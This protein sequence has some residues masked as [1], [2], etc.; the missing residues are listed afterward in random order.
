MQ[1]NMS[2]IRIRKRNNSTGIIKHSNFN[3][4]EMSLYSDK[5]V[6]IK[7][8]AFHIIEHWQ[9]L[10]ENTNMSFDK[11]LYVFEEICKNCT[12]GEINSA[13]GV[14][15]EA[16]TKVRDVTQLMNSIKYRNSR[17]KTK[18]STKV[19]NNLSNMATANNSSIDSLSN[20]IHS[21]ISSLNGG[22]QSQS[23]GDTSGVAQECFTKLLD[24]AKVMNECDRIIKNYNII[25]K[26]FN[27]NKMVSE[28][29][30][31]EEVYDTIIEMCS[32]I[33]TYNTEFKNKYNTALENTYYVFNNNYM[34]YPAEKIV[35]SV[36]DYFI[37]NNIVTDEDVNTISTVKESNVV[38][39]KNDFNRV[40]YLFKNNKIN[41]TVELDKEAASNYGVDFYTLNESSLKKKVKEWSKGNPDEH[42][43]DDT[44]K[45]VSDFRDSC[46]EKKSENLTTNLKSLIT[47]LFTK[48]PEQITKELPNIFSIIR[49]FFILGTVPINPIITLVLFIADNMIKLNLERKHLDK[50]IKMYDKEIEII[51]GK[52]EKDKS[53]NNKDRLNKYLEALKK[54]LKKIKEYEEDLYTDNENDERHENDYEFDDDDTD[55]DDWDLDDDDDWNF[56]ESQLIKSSSIIYI[57]ELVNSINEALLDDNIDGVVYNNIFKFNDDTID[58]ITDFSIT[59]PLI[60]EKDKL[61]NSLESLRNNIRENATNVNDF[62]RIDCLN[63][64]I[65]KIKNS[66]NSFNVA[67]D[68]KGI[69]CTLKWLEEMTKSCNSE[70]IT[71][72][73]FTNTLKLSMNRL[74]KSAIKLSGK[75]KQI[76]N[77]ID[78]SMR[79][80]SKGMED[81]MLKDNKE[82]II[83]GRILPSA[84]RVIKIALTTGAAW[85]VNPAIAVIGSLGALACTKKTRT[86]ERQLILDDIEIELKMCERYLRIA[87]DKNDMKAVRQIEVTQRNLQ[88]QQ[89]RIKYKMNV[90]YGQ[91]VPD[92]GKNEDND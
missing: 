83:K 32:C 55:L 53:S 74:K 33:D 5:D 90:V 12:S 34:N 75:E 16:I 40:N 7:N 29:S 27:F 1:I 81:S 80:I 92:V 64:N 49:V 25:S 15:L 77:D 58:A 22:Q 71:E 18:I 89:Q 11:A 66:H 87:E 91:N 70:Y 9:E 37:M 47:K 45:M 62:I 50:I 4:N 85:A 48:N 78:V 54:D 52:I 38:F 30:N 36:T 42:D 59:V 8:N 23:N 88:R 17:I 57:S 43:N 61:C 13:C 2:D 41:N 60:L 86:K 56:D 26:R 69:I 65:Y 19:N 73:D 72:M 24:T 63:D 3:I 68:T 79:N 35:E 20:K 28:I 51:N 67:N 84:S 44:K 39:S 82:A 21:A 31:E 14:L 6:F 10:N 76:S 46:R